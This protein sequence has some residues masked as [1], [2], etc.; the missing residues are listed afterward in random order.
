MYNYHLPTF[1]AG[2]DYD[3]ICAPDGELMKETAKVYCKHTFLKWED[4][5]GDYRVQVHA[6]DKFGVDSV[7]L[8]NTFYYR[9]LTAF[10]TDFTSVAYGDVKLDTHKIINGDL[11]FGTSDKPTVRNVGNTRLQMTVWQDD[12]GLGKTING[13]EWWNVSWDARVG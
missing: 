10:E 8:N 4:P 12:M 3:E 5:A 9:P 13:D 2:Y 1:N 11:T 6:A 7:P